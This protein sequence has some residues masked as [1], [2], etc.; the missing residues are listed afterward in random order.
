MGKVVLGLTISTR[1]THFNPASPNLEA[2]GAVSVM[3]D[4]EY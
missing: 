1:A 4:Q 2:V 3:I